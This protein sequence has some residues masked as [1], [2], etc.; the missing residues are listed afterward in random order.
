MPNGHPAV[1]GHIKDGWKHVSQ[2]V[3]SAEMATQLQQMDLSGNAWMRNSTE[4]RGSR[5]WVLSP[6]RP[7]AEQAWETTREFGT[8]MEGKSWQLTDTHHGEQTLKTKSIKDG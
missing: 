6:G 4:P 5:V 8:N 3:I 7:T 2:A 1:Q